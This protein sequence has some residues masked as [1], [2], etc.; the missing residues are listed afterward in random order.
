MISCERP[1]KN[2][3]NLGERTD[4]CFFCSWHKEKGPISISSVLVNWR[5]ATTCNMKANQIEMYVWRFQYSTNSAHIG[6]VCGDHAMFFS[7]KQLLKNPRDISRIWHLPSSG[8]IHQYF[9]WIQKTGGDWRAVMSKI[10][11]NASTIDPD[12][13]ARNELPHLDFVLSRGDLF[14]RL[15]SPGLLIG[16]RWGSESHSSELWIEPLTPGWSAEHVL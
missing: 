15:V 6:R 2:R 4:Q 9:S 12:E 1:H 3:G 16:C 14:A 13:M 5:I 10:I 8:C 11:E 7:S